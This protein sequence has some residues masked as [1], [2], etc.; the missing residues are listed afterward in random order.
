MYDTESDAGY[1]P[2][3]EMIDVDEEDELADE[4]AKVELLALDDTKLVKHND[5]E[6]VADDEL[7]ADVE[8][9]AGPA[10]VDEE[11]GLD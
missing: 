3:A 6:A 9:V 2:D 5:P 8:L 11:D 4:E 10:V 1:V 7:E